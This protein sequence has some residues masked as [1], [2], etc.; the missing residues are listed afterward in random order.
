MAAAAAAVL[1][2]TLLLLAQDMGK[3]VELLRAMA[4]LYKALVAVAAAV[5]VTP[6]RQAAAAAA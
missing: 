5:A 4:L 2:G 3:V 1:V 6:V